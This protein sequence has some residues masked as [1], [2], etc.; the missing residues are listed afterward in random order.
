VDF[1]TKKRQVKKFTEQKIPWLTGGTFGRP[2]KYDS[3]PLPFAER[4]RI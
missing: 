2:V 3:Q 4:R 1:A